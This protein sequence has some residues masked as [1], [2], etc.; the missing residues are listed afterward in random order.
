MKSA[1]LVK[2][3]AGILLWSAAVVVNT[4]AAAVG[5]EDTSYSRSYQELMLSS[6]QGRHYR[7]QVSVPDAAAPKDGYPV[8][9]VLDGNGWFGPAADIARMREYEKLSPIIVVG[10]APAGK[11][12]FDVARSY[13]FTSPGTSDP[14]FEGIPLGGADRFLE[15]LDGVVKPSRVITSMPIGASCS[16]TQWAACLCCTRC[17]SHRGVSTYIW[18]R[19][20]ISNTAARPSSR[21]RR[22]SSR[23]HGVP[24]RDCW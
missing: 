24:R 17:S 22:P 21:K 23:I 11:A 8:L 13:D 16:A 19:A 2:V 12:F 18:P 7:V 15:F 20:R 1:L 4:A 10:I 6:K 9:Y 5:K 14:D 3:A